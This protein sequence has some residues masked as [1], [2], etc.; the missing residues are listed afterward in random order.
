MAT[1]HV[2]PL[3]LGAAAVGVTATSGNLPVNTSYVV[4]DQAST[5]TATLPDGTITGQMMTI[6][7]LGNGQKTITV[8]NGI[9]TASDGIV[10]AASNPGQSVLL[11]WTGSKWATLMAE[12]AGTVS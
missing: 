1:T 10:L 11:M 8:T 3:F 4:I 7:S 2:F 9:S 12:G 6:V 5:T